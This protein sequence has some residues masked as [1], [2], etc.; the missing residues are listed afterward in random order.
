MTSRGRETEKKTKVRRTFNLRL[1]ARLILA[2][3]LIAL[4]PLTLLTV[5]V[6]E[7]TQSTVTSMVNA[8]LTD[9][10][11]R[12][13]ASIASSIQQLTYDLQNLAVNPSIEQLAVIRPTSILR[14]LG[15]EGKTVEE[16]E[17]MMAE[18]RNLEGNSRTQAF[19]ESTVAEYQRFSQLI[20]VNMDGMVLGATERPDRF[21]HL[22]EHWFQAAIEQEVYISDFQQLPDKDEAGLVMSTVIYRSS[23]LATGAARPA[24]A[25]RGLVPMSFF[26]DT[27]VP[28]LA[29]IAGGE[30]QLLSSGQ[31]VLDIK[32]T[33]QGPAVEIFLAGQRPPAIS[34][35]D[36]ES[37]AAGLTSGGEEALT[38]AARVELGENSSFGHSWEIRIA[39]PTRYALSLVHR[40]STLGYVGI[41]VTGLVVVIV[42]FILARDISL[43]L[44]Q[45]TA[46][47]RDVAQGRLRQYKPKKLRR[48][49]TGE[50]T[51]A[52]N[53]MTAQLA[54]LL[55]RVRSASEALAT[56]SQ[57]ISAGMEEM[58]A[59]AQTQSEDVQSGT[60]R[61]EEMNEAM[62]AMEQRAKEAV[63]L[64]QNATEAAAQ[65][66]I[67]AGEAVEGMNTIKQS[68]ESLTKQTQEI[69]KILAL[70]RDIAE[71]TNLL[72][73]NAAIEAAR[74]G[75]QGR[76][77][78]V[79]AQEVGDLAIRS[80]KATEEIEQALKRI[81]KDTA[82]SLESVEKGQ[83]E[84]HEVR[85][86]L[87]NITQAAK[88]TEAL[89]QQ[90]AGESLAQAARTREAVA[91]FLSI[92]EITEQTAAGTEETAAAAQNL[93]ELAQQLQEI[94]ASFQEQPEN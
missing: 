89:V 59:G 4:I 66:E 1:R 50:L 40:L 93:A 34:L 74:A 26:S 92:G 3:A 23:S 73:L 43:P 27:M 69:G 19:L 30:L 88:E 77:F 94:I 58:A 61:I 32:N 67:Q 18:T 70:I 91:L 33:D 52:F 82:R 86:A 49:E 85:S 17:E 81:Q 51:T 84:V 20:V 75:E 6:I 15:L 63:V 54:R 48:D 14:D 41:V 38:A 12:I 10:A 22:D 83:Q 24:G 28:I 44:V 72:A 9:Q 2:F 46:H 79:V 5:V 25:V 11:N 65:G 39:Q 57:E 60:R 62:A 42:A 87:Q 31:V 90:I 21:I 71:Q 36:A 16:M 37:R 29:D 53:E 68:V 78:A 80:Q 13:A 55:H 7:Q 45:L 64:S 56:S 35:A 8:T 76:S 47:A